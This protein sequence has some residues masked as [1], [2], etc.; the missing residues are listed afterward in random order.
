MR[1]ITLSVVVLAGL[2]GGSAVAQMSTPMNQQGVPPRANPSTGA[3]PGNEIGT[4]KSM[5]MGNAASNIT[6]SDTRSTIAPNLPSPALGPDAPPADYLRAAQGA[7]GTGRTGEAQ[8]ALEMAE[9][10]LLDRSV[11][12]S[13]INASS[14]NPTVLQ[15]A[16]ALQALAAGNRVQC[17]QLIQAAIPAAQATGQ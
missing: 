13:Q 16:A 9:T 1:S 10:R 3:R 14:T 7:L 8:Q 2:A 15:I 5:P 17:M 12:Q 11:P 4:G 6:P